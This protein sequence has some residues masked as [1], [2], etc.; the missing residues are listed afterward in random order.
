M[1]NDFDKE[2]KEMASKSKIKEPDRLKEK[3]SLTFKNLKR[4]NKPFK[5]LIG[6]VAALVLCTLIFTISFPTYAEDIPGIKQVMEFLNSRFELD[7]YSDS[8]K[9]VSYSIDLGEYKLNIDNVYY[10][11]IDLSVFYNITSENKLD[12]ESKYWFLAEIEA[13]KGIS[14]MYVLEN[15]DFI[16]DNTYAGMITFNIQYHDGSNLPE[17]FKGTMDITQ[18]NIQNTK[19]ENKDS[20]TSSIEV[21]EKPLSLE[22]DSR[23]IPTQEYKIGKEIASEDKTINIINGTKYPTGIYID[24]KYNAGNN[25]SNLNY[26]LWDSKK[27]RLENIGGYS[28]D[29][30]LVSYKYELP[31][32]D[33]DVYIVPHVDYT[34]VEYDYSE[35]NQ[36]VHLIENGKKYDFGSYGTIEIKS[37]ENKDNKTFVTV[38]VTGYQA[39]N[40]FQLVDKEVKEYYVPR[41]EENKK[42]LGILDM[43]VTYVFNELDLNEDYYIEAPKNDGKY[44]FKILTDK[45]IKLD[46]NN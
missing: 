36:D 35:S 15:G 24:S 25:E 44:D 31:S 17:I 4:K 38:Q 41:Y 29:I 28:K 13:D 8:S 2:L 5:K 40:R 7:G 12:L 20:E 34:Y 14:Y 39:M 27:G 42:I 19:A 43:E 21:V 3:V 11:G 10:D 46:I 32:E 18:I 37:I 9:E 23:N 1:N 6:T 33:G 22:L 30:G 45:I 16:D 26:I